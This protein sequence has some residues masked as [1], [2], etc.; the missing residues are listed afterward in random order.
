MSDS[1]QTLVGAYGPD[2]FA[3][4]LIGFVRRHKDVPFF[5]YYPMALTHDPFQPTPGH[6]EYDDF[7]PATMRVNDPAYFADNVAHM[8]KVVG[9]IADALEEIGIRE[10]TLILFIGDNGTDRDIVSPFGDGEIRGIRAIPQ[11]MVPTCP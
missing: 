5:A 10:N 7:D 6:P 11:S 4:S 2:V 3:D 8:D 9:R 1:V